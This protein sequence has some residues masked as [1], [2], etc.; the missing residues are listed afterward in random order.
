MVSKLR[1]SV[2]VNLFY[3]LLDTQDEVVGLVL[4]EFEDALHLDFHEAE[5]VV[6]GHL[7]D[8]LGIIGG[9]TLIDIL[10]GGIHI[11]CVLKGFSLVD[12]L[13]DEDFLQRGKMELFEQF[14]LAYLQFL[15]Q[16]VFGVVCGVAQQVADSE[17]LRPFVD[18]DAAVGRDVDFAVGKGIEG[19]DG[20]V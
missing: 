15:P 5:D 18:D 12:A 17:E 13:L 7:A 6:L 14:A 9:E 3:L 8:K 11:R 20:L 10:A 2:I 1:I 16:Q 19:V 4:V